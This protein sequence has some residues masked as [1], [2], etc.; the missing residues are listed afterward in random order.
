[1]VFIS[2]MDMN[3]WVVLGLLWPCIELSWESQ[4]YSVFYSAW[5]W[6]EQ[7]IL[8]AK[9]PFYGKVLPKEQLAKHIQIPRYGQFV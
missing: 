1:M 8:S 9:R 2:P 5:S 3:L 6:N 4:C 7:N